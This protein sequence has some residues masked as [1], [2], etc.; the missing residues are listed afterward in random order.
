MAGPEGVSTGRRRHLSPRAVP[1]AAALDDDG[2]AGAYYRALIK[3][4]PRAMALLVLVVVV[5]LTSASTAWWLVGD[6]S[7]TTTGSV[8]HIVAPPDISSGAALAI[9][10]GSLLIGGIAAASMLFAPAMGRREPGWRLVVAL[11]VVVGII[12]GYG[13]RVLTAGTAGANQGAGLIVLAGVPVVLGLLATAGIRSFQL[14]AA[15]EQGR[16]H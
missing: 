3:V 10:L 5:L 8:T 7:E 2:P 16:D 15:S 11:V 1:Q 14:L 13:W 4:F 12:V 6:L 9:G